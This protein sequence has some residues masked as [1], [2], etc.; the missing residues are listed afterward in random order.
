MTDVDQLLAEFIAEDRAGGVADPSAYLARADEGARAELSALLDGYLARAPRRAFSR[1]AFT[2]SPAHG[3]VD[4]LDRTLYGSSG[5][6]PSLLPRLRDRARMRR[7][8]LVTQLAAAL[9]LP[10]REAKVG[11]YYHAM[12]QGTLP[13]AGVSQRVLEALGRLV[14]ESADVL[15]R[16]GEATSAPPRAGGEAFARVASAPAAPAAAPMRARRPARDEVDE[17]FTSG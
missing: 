17:L 12:E 1:A 8:D 4:D 9:D 15:R 5:T 14:G 7:S 10:G 2:A 16:A 3:L 11:A 6:W 13:S